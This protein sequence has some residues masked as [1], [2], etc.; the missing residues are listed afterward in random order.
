VLPLGVAAKEFYGVA[1]KGL[2]PRG[3]SQGVA[4]KGL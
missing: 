4:A 1:A 2:Q 3:V